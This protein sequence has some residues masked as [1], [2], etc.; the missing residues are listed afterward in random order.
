MRSAAYKRGG[1]M[2][3]WKKSHMIRFP[4]AQLS[5]DTTA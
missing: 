4:T 1:A 3:R 2:P 5:V